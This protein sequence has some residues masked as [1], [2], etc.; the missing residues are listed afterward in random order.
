MAVADTASLEVEVSRNR[1]MLVVEAATVFYG[2]EHVDV[3]VTLVVADD[4]G[5]SDRGG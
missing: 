3:G 5:G 1:T 2:D 4:R